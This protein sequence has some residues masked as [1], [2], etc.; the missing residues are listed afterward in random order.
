VFINISWQITYS[1]SFGDNKIFP[2]YT[3][4]TA[5]TICNFVARSVTVTSS[6]AAELPRPWPASLLIGFTVISLIASFFMP[7]Y[8][9]EIEFEERENK[10][11]N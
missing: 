1:I 9:E 5:I 6:L 11:L 2:F 8:S 4:A 10:I 3:R 7:S